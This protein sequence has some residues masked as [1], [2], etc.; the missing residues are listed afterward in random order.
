ML[1]KDE[2]NAGSDSLT[3]YLIIPTARIVCSNI[4]SLDLLPFEIEHLH[5]DS[6]MSA[7]SGTD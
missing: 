5:C 6:L 2:V 1:C 7:D 3:I 4:P